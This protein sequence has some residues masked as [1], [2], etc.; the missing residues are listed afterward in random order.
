MVYRV[1]AAVLRCALLLLA[2]R[3][4]FGMV[5]KPSKN[6]SDNVAVILMAVVI[7]GMLVWLAIKLFDET[8]KHHQ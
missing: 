3:L 7:C 8:P 5:A 1:G 6:P 2:I 4:F